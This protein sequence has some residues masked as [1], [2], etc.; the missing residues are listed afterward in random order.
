MIYGIQKETSIKKGDTMK[1]KIKIIISIFIVSVSNSLNAQESFKLLT[2]NLQ[3][4]SPQVADYTP[5]MVSIYFG[6][7]MECFGVRTLAQALKRVPGVELTIDHSG[8]WQTV[9]RGFSRTFSYG[10]FKFLLNNVSLNKVF[11]INS[12]PHMPISQIDRIEVIKGPMSVMYGEFAMSGIVNI[13]TKDR[14]TIR[15]S[16]NQIYSSVASDNYFSSGGIFYLAKDNKVEMGI[17]IAHSTSNNDSIHSG[18][19]RAFLLSDTT[20]APGKTNEKKAFTSGIANFRYDKFHVQTFGFFHE[21]GDYFG[22]DQRLPPYNDRIVYR[23]YQIGVSAQYDIHFTPSVYAKCLL[24]FQKQQLKGN[25]IYYK[26][27]IYGQQFF[28]LIYEDSIVH[29]EIDL[30]WKWG[31]MQGAPRNTLL[32]GWSLSKS[33]LGDTWFESNFNPND[34]NRHLSFHIGADELGLAD[35]HRTI[36]N[37]TIQD[38]FKFTPKLSS[39]AS[40]RYE[41]YSDLS[42]YFIP[43]LAMVYRFNKSHI[44]KMQYSSAFRP[45]TLDEMYGKIS[46]L[47]GNPEL[48]PETKETFEFGYIFRERDMDCVIRLTAFYSNLDDVIVFENRKRLNNGNYLLKGLE[49]EYKQKFFHHIECTSNLSY[50]DTKDRKFNTK[51]PESSDFMGNINIKYAIPEQYALALSYRYVGNKHREYADIR[52]PLASYQTLDFTISTYNFL[53]N[54]DGLSLRLGV[55]NILDDEI[56]YPSLLYDN[57]ATYPGDFSRSG[58]QFWLLAR[59]K[60]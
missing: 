52:Q 11:W 31:D 54:I 33:A 20:Y 43:R 28:D 26:E 39:T 45:P 38:M 59:Y 21:Q 50:V 19:D 47:A 32:V 46:P 44:V 53:G 6:N 25:D 12:L 36:H 16:I 2:T 22:F 41:H 3:M 30:F 29:T 8:V 5:G 58:R 9:M 7:D 40:I 4:K 14:S 49:M 1:Q 55:S 15:E 42:E 18:I 37:F 17:N 56:K 34:P 13:V 27:D 60:L 23:D 48:V 51:L 35:K 57:N 24:D 10:N